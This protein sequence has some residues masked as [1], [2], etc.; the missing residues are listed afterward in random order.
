M[1]A[2]II[3]FFKVS[4]ASFRV[5]NKASALSTL[6]QRSL[7]AACRSSIRSTHN[8]QK[9]TAY[10]LRSMIHCLIGA[11]MYVSLS[12]RRHLFFRSNKH[13]KFVDRDVDT[14][15]V[16]HDMVG[17]DSAANKRLSF[18]GLVHMDVWTCP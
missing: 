10:D 6:V 15:W 13:R 16:H 4:R 11:I 1:Y 5:G 3:L 18:S 17:R 9:P 8:R 14:I 2:Y 7:A 12:P